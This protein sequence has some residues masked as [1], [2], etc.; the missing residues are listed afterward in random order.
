MQVAHIILLIVVLAF[1]P[2]ISF[3]AEIRRVLSEPA[4]TPTPS[5]TYRLRVRLQI[6]FVQTLTTAVSSENFVANTMAVDKFRSAVVSALGGTFQKENVIVD[7][8]LDR[9][10]SR[11]TLRSGSRA[12]L[13][14]QGRALTAALEVHYAIM[15]EKLN[16]NPSTYTLSTEFAAELTAILDALAAPSLP[17]SII[18][19]LVDPDVGYTPIAVVSVQAAVPPRKISDIAVLVLESAP[20]PAPGPSSPSGDADAYSAKSK[21]GVIAG[22]GVAII[23]LMMAVK[24]FVLHEWRPHTL[25]DDAQNANKGQSKVLPAEEEEEVPVPAAATDV[26]HK[27]NIKKRMSA[28]QLRDVRDSGQNTP[29]G[30]VLIGH[31]INTIST[32]K[33]HDLRAGATQERREPSFVP[34]PGVPPAHKAVHAKDSCDH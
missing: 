17:Q 26:A 30:F 25:E 24:F 33:E 19:A 21:V 7:S 31:G 18:D 10:S 15:L 2:A 34:V 6:P 16:I 9:S 13:D 1:R 3:P 28:A 5:P 20:T 14:V 11:R 29:S 8:V 4:L 12:Q 27:P 22:G 23:I 32:D